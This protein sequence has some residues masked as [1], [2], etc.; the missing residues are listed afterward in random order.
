M[1]RLLPSPSS[2]CPS[3][4]APDIS[5]HILSFVVLPV[6]LSSLFTAT[7]DSSKH[8]PLNHHPLH[9]SLP[10]FFAYT[11]RRTSLSHQQLWIPLP[12]TTIT[13]TTLASEKGMHPTSQQLPPPPPSTPLQIGLPLPF[14]SLVPGIPL[15][16]PPTS[17]PLPRDQ[18]TPTLLTELKVTTVLSNTSAEV[19]LPSLSSLRRSRN[20]LLRVRGR[21]ELLLLSISPRLGYPLR[22]SERTIPSSRQLLRRE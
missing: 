3:G 18:P 14:L 2:L 12:S 1:S 4:Q 10:S 6:S 5:P 16:N 15:P 22:R 13:T 20:T 9:P 8:F 19:D 11:R 21:I 7:V 17:L